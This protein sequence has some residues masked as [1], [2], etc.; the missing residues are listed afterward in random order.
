VSHL[1]V[2]KQLDLSAP[3]VEGIVACCTCRL[4]QWLVV[5]HLHV[6][7]TGGVLFLHCACIVVVRMA[8]NVG[9]NLLH[10]LHRVQACMKTAF[11][12]VSYFQ[13]CISVGTVC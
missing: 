7:A 4:K 10:G 12:I 5:V 8:Q 6:V 1:E 11:R 9:S 13:L 2:S 3:V